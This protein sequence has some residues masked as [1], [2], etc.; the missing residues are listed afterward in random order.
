MEFNLIGVEV[1][2]SE[3]KRSN[4]HVLF[5]HYFYLDNLLL[6]TSHCFGDLCSL[7]W[8]EIGLGCMI[9]L[10]DSNIYGVTLK[11]KLNVTHYKFK[12]IANCYKFN[13]LVFLIVIFCY[14]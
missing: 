7:I 6:N 3:I 1:N 10:T 14:L 13:T 2:Y 8:G 4:Q 5:F 11:T 9:W 12:Y